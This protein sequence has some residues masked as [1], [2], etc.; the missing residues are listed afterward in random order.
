[1]T[2]EPA[3]VALVTA[4]SQGIGAALSAFEASS[5][6]ACSMQRGRGRYRPA[7]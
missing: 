1:M 6:A 5:R 2:P 3:P 7:E 4:V